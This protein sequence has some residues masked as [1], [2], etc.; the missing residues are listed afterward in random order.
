MNQT[1]IA[2]LIAIQNQKVAKNK[3]KQKSTYN[4]INILADLTNNGNKVQA[5]CGRKKQRKPTEW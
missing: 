1:T 3:G 5:S 4:K 2:A